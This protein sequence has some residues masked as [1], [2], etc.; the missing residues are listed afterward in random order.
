MGPT[1][2][3]DERDALHEARVQLV[4]AARLIRFDAPMWEKNEANA[5]ANQLE[6]YADILLDLERRLEAPE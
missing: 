4:R 5:V 3:V 1:L 2:T 6:R